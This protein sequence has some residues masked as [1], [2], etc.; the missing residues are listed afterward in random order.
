MTQLPQRYREN[1]FRRYEQIIHNATEQWPAATKCDPT[2][3][4]I[5]QATFV[6][7]LRDAIKSYYD[8]SWPSNINRVKFVGIYQEMLVSERVDGTILIG[9]REAIKNWCAVDNTPLMVP[10]TPH[11]A[12]SVLHLTAAEMIMKLSH[13]RLL[14]PRIKLIDLTD[15]E[16]DDFQQK[17]DISLDKNLDGSHTLI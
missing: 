7:R 8:H 3:L 13:L 5:A 6:C 12:I 9:H 16:A 15:I 10:E 11:D 1:Q 4:N 14:A 2:L 17:Y